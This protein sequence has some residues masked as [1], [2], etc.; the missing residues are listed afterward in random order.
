MAYIFCLALA[1]AAR[2]GVGKRGGFSYLS[3]PAMN[4]VCPNWS[5]RSVL[6]FVDFF[7]D[8]HSF[9][10]LAHSFVDIHLNV[11]VF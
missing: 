8:F 2:L 4:G 9:E 5:F 1:S 10:Y 3:F 7:C 11:P 6:N